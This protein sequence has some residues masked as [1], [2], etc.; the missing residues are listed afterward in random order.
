MRAEPSPAQSSNYTVHSS[1]KEVPEERKEDAAEQS[2]RTDTA[3]LKDPT[4]AP[5]AR[6]RIVHRPKEAKGNPA[7]TT[8]N[9]VALDHRPTVGP[10]EVNFRK[11]LPTHPRLSG[12]EAIRRSIPGPQVERTRPRRQ[13]H[14]RRPERWAATNC[15]VSSGVHRSGRSIRPF[16]HIIP[17]SGKQGSQ[18][19]KSHFDWP[20]CRRFYERMGELFHNPS[21]PTGMHGP[22]MAAQ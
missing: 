17:E 2:R 21:H 4:A 5:S 15:L 18:R 20:D 11:N 14:W 3:L 10:I 8:R 1:R 12:Q 22:L 16:S 7:A 13:W 19:W 9:A 6:P